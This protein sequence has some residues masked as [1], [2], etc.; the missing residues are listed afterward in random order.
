[1]EKL[2]VKV[3]DNNTENKIGLSE[4]KCPNQFTK[5]NNSRSKRSTKVSLI[6]CTNILMIK[7]VS[8]IF[9]NIIFFFFSFKN[10]SLRNING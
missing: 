1:M 4:I 2:C 8:N 7:S 9:Q 10:V 5:N 6:N 3:K